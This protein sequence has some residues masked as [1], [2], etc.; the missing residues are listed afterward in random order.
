MK[1]RKKRTSFVRIAGRAIFLLFKGI[2]IAI[3]WLV[4]K[5]IA[6]VR[7]SIQKTK[8]QDIEKKREILGKQATYKPFILVENISGSLPV[9]E[10]ILFSPKSTIG[11]ILGARGTGKSVIGMRILEDVKTKVKRPCAAM[12]FDK[13]KLPR[14][15]TAIN[16]INEI[17]NGSFVLIDEGGILF[18][19]RNAMK[20]ANKLLSELLLIA[21]HKDLSILFITQNSA[22]LEINAI[23]QADYLLLK[24]SSLLQRDFERKKIKEM[25]DEVDKHFEK[26][27]GKQGLTYLYSDGFRG[28]VTNGLP[29][30]WST[31]LSKSFRERKSGG[32][33]HD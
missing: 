13:E 17:E 20:D 12:G 32:G 8:E 14:W 10:N 1:K 19:S 29:S 6:L 3:H 25:Y 31:E 27:K 2:Y 5:I 30:F 28:F 23:R 11:I 18:G 22:N 33:P 24:P 21:R 16:D 4:L 9:F 15:I 26:Y 7:W